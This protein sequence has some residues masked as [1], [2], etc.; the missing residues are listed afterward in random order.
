MMGEPNPFDGSGFWWTL[1]RPFLRVAVGRYEAI[2]RLLSYVMGSQQAFWTAFAAAL[3][4]TG[5]TQSLV[6]V[7]LI[8]IFIWNH[9]RPVN[10]SFLIALYEVFVWTWT[11]T[12]VAFGLSYVAGDRTAL[13]SVVHALGYMLLDG[14]LV[15]MFVDLGK[16]P[17]K[18]KKVKVRL[19]VPKTAI[20]PVAT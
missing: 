15:Y 2:G 20:E 1:G 6:G 19:R 11:I 9:Q 13:S 5:L 7:M 4:L 3:V 18:R 8:F 12:F 17:R 14:L 16:P 10:Q